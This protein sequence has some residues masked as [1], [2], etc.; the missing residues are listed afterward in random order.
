LKDGAV[1]LIDLRPSMTFRKGHIAGSRWSIRSLLASE[2][3]GEQRPLVL[4]ADDPQ[5]A[6]FAAL[7]LPDVQRAQTRLLSG[8]VDAWR[9]AGFALQEDANT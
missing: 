3:A 9:E 6:A 8:G 2:V 1:A 5:L 4:L 7:E